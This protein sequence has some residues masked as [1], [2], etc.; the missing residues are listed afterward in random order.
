MPRATVSD[1]KQI[2]N[3]TQDEAVII[4]HIQAANELVSEILGNETGISSQ[5][6]RFIE[7]YLTA[8]FLSIGLEKHLG[9]V[10]EYEVG[11]TKIKYASAV[12]SS[13][14]GS[15][16]YG[17]TAKLLDTTGKLSGLGRTRATFRAFGNTNTI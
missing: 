3:T 1:V 16:P 14:L 15:T 5:L 13:G 11:D 4:T 17:E 7:I 12:S 10:E 6:K 8:H 2:I 9:G